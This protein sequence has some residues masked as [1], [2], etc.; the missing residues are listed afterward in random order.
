MVPL[1]CNI[2]QSYSFYCI[3]D[4]ENAVF[5]CT[6]KTSFKTIRKSYQPQTTE[7]HGVNMDYI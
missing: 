6:K 1:N 4:R 7:V 5:V 2:S 3:Y